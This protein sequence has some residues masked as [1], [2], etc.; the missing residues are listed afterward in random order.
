MGFWVHIGINWC[1]WVYGIYLYVYGFMGVPI[2]FGCLDI[3]GCHG[4]LW[5]SIVVYG[6]LG[7]Y[8]YLW[9]A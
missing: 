6:F 8:R 7:G 1:L 2:G 9:V 5:V 4:C 3:Y